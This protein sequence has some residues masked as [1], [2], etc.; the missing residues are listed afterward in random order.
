MTESDLQEKLDFYIDENICKEKLIEIE[1]KIKDIIGLDPE[2]VRKL[3]EKE[4]DE[5]KDLLGKRMWILNNMFEYTPV[6]L[7]RVKKV[8]DYLKNLSAKL[9]DRVNAMALKAMIICYDPTFDDDFE[10]KGCLMY[11]YN[12]K[13]SV[14]TLDDDEYYGSDFNF[15][16]NAID[17]IYFKW[18]DRY[19][20]ILTV[21]P[22]GTNL[23]NE[24]RW[25]EPPLSNPEIEICYAVHEIVCHRFFSIP[26]LVRLNDFWAEVKFV[27]QSI[28]N[29]DGKRWTSSD[30]NLAKVKKHHLK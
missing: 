1:R 10:I 2:N 22:N 16:I 24:Y 21:Y 27:E 13:T 3:N 8:N 18:D 26:D 11:S 7:E 12:D 20:E 30:C 15:M 25:N 14:L 23:D 17:S 4:K 5:L 19:Y 9:Y 6:N 28:T 29:Q